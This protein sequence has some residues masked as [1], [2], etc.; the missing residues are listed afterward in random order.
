MDTFLQQAVN[1]V[2]LG[3]IYA[4]F[5]LGYAL[6]FRG[7]GVLNLAHSALFAWGALVGVVAVRLLGL[8]VWLALPAAMLVTGLLGLA[9]EYAAFRPLRQRGAPR[10]SQL[11][12]SIGA[13][14]L[15]VS[16]A[17]IVYQNLIG[18]VQSFFPRDLIPSTP[19]V[20]EGLGI[21]V[22]PIRVMVLALAL[23]LMLALNVLVARSRVGQQMRAVA[24]NQRTASLLGVNVG[25]IFVF[26][27]FLAGALGGAAGVLYGL[28]FTT[29]DPFI[30]QDV[31][32]IGLTAVVLGGMGSINGAVLGGFLVAAIQTASISIGG[33]DYRNAIVFLLLFVLLLVR[34]QGLLGEPDS[35]RA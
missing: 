4:L 32:L 3:A 26:T 9:L 16:T 5:S 8:P 23:V 12:S 11:I 7:R 25:Q 28:V 10:I 20:I 18:E 34:P 21:S 2:S 1:A 29:V 15:L 31:A 35:T 6:V 13:S 14:I 30:G 27:F 17:Q 22:T 24:Y 19:I 33:S